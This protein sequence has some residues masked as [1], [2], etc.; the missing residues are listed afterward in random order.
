MT[1]GIKILV[2][3]C[4]VALLVGCG[5]KTPGVEERVQALEK[6]GYMAMG[7]RDYATAEQKYQEAL[8]LDPENQS[9]QNNLAI[10]YVQFLDKPEK[11]EKI[12]LH[13]QEKWPRNSAYLNNLAGIYLSQKKYEASIAMYEKAKDPNPTYHMPYYNIGNIYLLQKKYGEAVKE[14]RQGMHK[15]PRDSHLINSLAKAMVLNGQYNRS[16]QL[17]KRKYRELESIRSVALNLTRLTQKLDKLK[18][19]EQIINA[20]LENYPTEFSFLAEQIELAFLQ[21]KSVKEIETLLTGMSPNLTDKQKEWYPTLYEARISV[22]KKDSDKALELLN[23][24]EGKIP[25]NMMLFE[26]IR[27]YCLYEIYTSKGQTAEA[28]SA[29]KQ[30]EDQAPFRFAGLSAESTAEKPQS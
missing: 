23:G 13:M 2:A 17:L 5:S 1:K 21:E 7:S 25:S 28:E 20:Y 4:C 14:L 8:E 30:A 15:A 22:L 11:A 24:L 29:L 6:E 9:L 19:S 10:L 3:V 26:G 27:Q 16:Y 18:E 12:W